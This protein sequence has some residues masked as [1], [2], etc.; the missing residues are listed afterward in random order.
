MVSYRLR[1]AAEQDLRDIWTYGRTEWSVSQAEIYL[2][3]I[4]D[5]FDELAAFPLSGQDVS[6]IR[7]GYRR[8]LCGQHAVFYRVIDDGDVDIVRVLHQRMDVPEKF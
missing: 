1:P 2:N 3:A 7:P 5:L 6:W 4:F 8:R